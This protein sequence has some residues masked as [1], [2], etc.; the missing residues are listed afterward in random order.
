MTSPDETD[1]PTAPE[2]VTATDAAAATDGESLTECYDGLDW[3]AHPD[4][5]ALVAGSPLSGLRY[6]VDL[7]GPAHGTGPA[8]L[9]LGAFQ[10]LTPDLDDAG[11]PRLDLGHHADWQSAVD[12]AEIHDFGFAEGRVMADGREILFRGSRRQTALDAEDFAILRAHAGP[13]IG[14]EAVTAPNG[15]PF[16]RAASFFQAKKT[17]NKQNSDGSFTISLTLPAEDMP[18]WLTAAPFGSYLLLGAC[19]AGHEADPADAEAR[20]AIKDLIRRASL[21]PTEGAFQEFLANRY[22]R[23]GLLA[24]AMRRDSD[25]LEE[26]AAETLRRLIGVPTRKE[27]EVNLDARA[28]LERLDREYYEA[29]ARAVRLN[30]ARHGA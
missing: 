16:T 30:E 17:A 13:T 12:A 5:P 11:W 10:T 6:V 25:A 22:D 15:A 26:A 19:A 28:R 8:Q 18:L 14:G 1:A 24:A 7:R 29:M 20:K 2:P 4:A 27:L 9:W 23:W 3:I 21:R